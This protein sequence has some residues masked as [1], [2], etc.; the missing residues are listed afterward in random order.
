MLYDL[1]N[2]IE[3]QERFG[4]EHEEDESDGKPCGHYGCCDC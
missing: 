4:D 1:E 2:Y 3:K